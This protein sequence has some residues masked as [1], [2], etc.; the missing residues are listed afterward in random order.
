MSDL[1]VTLRIKTDAD[2]TVRAVRQV[3]QAVG[4]L[5]PQAQKSG[6][7]AEQGM[8]RARRGVDAVSSS[9]DR[10]QRIAATAFAGFISFRAV[11]RVFRD[12]V[13]NTTDQEAVLAQLEAR[14]QSTGGAAGRSIAQLTT[15]SRELQ[16][17]TTVAN[18]DIERMMGTLMTF[19]N[20]AGDQF[21]ASTRAILN[22]SAALGTDLQS[23]ALQVGKALNDPIR[24][25]DGLNRSGIQFNDT[26]REM[27]RDMAEA[28]DVAGAQRLILAELETQFGGAAEAAR[29]TFG[30]ALAGLRNAFDDLLK[31]Q[32]DL[33]SLTGQ[34]E[35]ITERLT[36]PALAEAIQAGLGAALALIPPA[37]DAAVMGLEGFVTVVTV[38]I[39]NVDLLVDGVI[40]LATVITTRLVLALAAKSAA[41]LTT[42]GSLNVLNVALLA[43][44]V[45][46]QALAAASRAGTAAL[47][48][49]GG[50]I[51]VVALALGG[52]VF[53]VRRYQRH[54]EEL[55]Q[56][57]EAAASAM[58]RMRAATQGA[59]ETEQID[60]FRA[61]TAK[62]NQE[63]RETEEALERATIARLSHRGMGS[64]RD[65][66]E[67]RA[68]RERLELYLQEREMLQEVA[69]ERR[70]LN[71]H[72]TG[73]AHHEDLASGLELFSRAGDAAIDVL[74]RL[75]L[76]TRNAA[77]GVGEMAAAREAITDPL[78]QQIAQ[79]EREVGVLELLAEGNRT[80]AEAQLEYQYQLDLTA[81]READAEDAT[82]N[83]VAAVERK[84][85]RLRELNGE[86]QD[87]QAASEAAAEAE[88][89]H[90]QRMQQLTQS[91]GQLLTTTNPLAARQ[92]ELNSQLEMMTELAGLSSE[93]LADMGVNGQLLQQVIAGLQQEL[94]GLGGDSSVLP[95][96]DVESYLALLDDVKR[97][98][99]EIADIEWR[100]DRVIE[101][102]DPLIAELG[103]VR[104]Q[105]A[106]VDDA[107]NKGLISEAQAGFVRTGVAANAAFD[108]VLSG[109]DS[110]SK[111]YQELAVAQQ[112]MNTL[113]G[114][115]AILQTAATAPWPM[116]FVAMAQMAAMVASLIGSLG[117]LGGGG[118]NLAE[119]RQ[120]TQG[121]GT[122]LGD[123]DAKSETIA[124][125]LEITAD[126]TSTLVGINRGMLHALQTMQQGIASAATLVARGSLDIDLSALNLGKS[127]WGF[128][129]T[130]LAD[131]GI[132][133]M[134][135]AITEMVDGAVAQAFT[136]TRRSN[137]FSTSYR[138][139]FE[140]LDDAINDQ[141]NLIFDS[142]IDS[143]T[144]AGEALGIP[145]DEIQS[146]IEQFE[147]AAQEISLEGLSAEEQQEELEAVFSAIF[148]D[149]AG[150]VI[151]F[152]DQFQQIGEGLGETLVR[153][154]TSVQ[155]TEEAMKRL[156][157]AIDAPDPERMA[158]ISVGLVEALG[159]IEQFITGMEGF[160]A[161]FAPESHQLSIATDD[162]TRAL[163]GV[164]LA[165]PN[166][167]DEMWQLMGTLD[168]STE[169][170]REQFAM[171]I[172][173]RD[174][175][176]TYYSH[177]E[178]IQNERLGLER[179]ILQLQGDTAALRE[180]ELEKLDDSNRALQLRIWALEEEAEL[181][182][183]MQGV[184]DEIARL[185]LHPLVDEFR[186][187]EKSHRDLVKRASELGASQQQLD[188]IQELHTIRLEQLSGRI[189][190]AIR[191]IGE[192]LFGGGAAG[193]DAFGSS[194][195]API[196]DAAN[197]IRDSLI[198]AL[199][200]VDEWLR[201]SAFEDP[202]LTKPQQFGA[203]QDEFE[204]LIQIAL[205]GEGQEQADA[206]SML[207]QLA[208]QLE[209]LGVQML[210]SA[211]PEFQSF[212]QDLIA[213]MEQV[214]GIEVPEE[215][216]PPTS[217]QV[218]AIQGAVEQLT[219]T[220]ADQA[221]LAA[222]LI[223][224]V[225]SLADITGQSPI[226]L[227][228]EMGYPLRDL[229]EM[230][231]GDIDEMSV[232]L[233]HQLMAVANA[234][235]ADLQDV[236]DAIGVN[237]GSLQEQDSLLSQA[238][239]DVVLGLPEE[240]QDELEEHLRNVWE[241]TEA[242]D[243]NEALDD[244]EKVTEGLPA[245]YRDLLKPFFDGIDPSD[246]LTDQLGL[247]E[248][249]KQIEQ[250]QLNAMQGVA[251]VLERVRKNL[252]AANGAAD[253]PGYA[254]GGWASGII[255]TGEIGPELVL[256][257][258]V[259][260]FL[261]RE[262]LPVNVG[263]GTDPRVAD[264]LLQLV[265]QGQQAAQQ[266]ER[267]GD[268]QVQ[269]VSHLSSVM[270][271]SERRRASERGLMA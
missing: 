198:R 243:A 23:A 126:A 155:V 67:E 237:I 183:M 200:G 48:L 90:S 162:L 250:Q 267:L 52:M 211:T 99:E 197:R 35:L 170:G 235:G 262:G 137:L 194:F 75:G 32:G 202:S 207:P 199:D 5:G 44:T 141:I 89:E 83:N 39:E 104:D 196:E 22:I 177:L 251:A 16:N 218:G 73:Q 129:S 6:R 215:Q 150:A 15:L 108:A 11:N 17:T 212:Y 247:L 20:I 259:S 240:I 135:G 139:Q 158:Q 131:Q 34:V 246:P 112:T 253:I 254:T 236:S 238:L 76:V 121:T 231:I 201:R 117:S 109:M 268:Q 174:A 269:V 50:P 110:S 42:A 80:A 168:A 245:K 224:L 59:F 19:T 30:G 114:I 40:L 96:A 172:E 181:S 147:V 21:D 43:A 192:Q 208:S 223:E 128:T 65:S 115:G 263:G 195:S 18:E 24:G 182:D 221:D 4:G 118:G 87:Y 189:R 105:I 188:R 31:F 143:V 9:L 124:Q 78:N 239:Q 138:T 165:V 63:I 98:M 185:T 103:H 169:A 123:P 77:G 217:A 106:A 140:E 92:L 25:M 233:V 49:M 55:S 148:D 88:Q 209:Q 100:F 60:E 152:I 270:I 153:V 62:L 102:F 156:G 2:G 51:G 226:E 157:L 3:N 95:G 14:I 265:E 54:L 134:G 228:Q 94:A 252:S 81:A 47:A 166:T 84:Y 161:K 204:R 82:L 38:V 205:T 193:G 216:Q 256:P 271:E 130:K 220:A 219:L 173:L 125:A 151:P 33:P 46:T 97:E 227:L 113:L 116:N 180:L 178:A 176:D 234:L 145:L 206:I 222:Q 91:Y 64:M 28:G 111:S 230:L 56:P 58:E 213:Q 53:A 210:G 101:S 74:E 225:G 119:R 257:H 133:L 72:M 127:D 7:E 146:R 29:G 266:R 93:Q 66:G 142:M 261:A 57:T 159:G 167:R 255:R 264:Y 242:A 36:D 85:A 71:E 10:V 249:I 186:N 45:Q 27:I 179:R 232:G 149:L 86:L 70:R 107:L 8:G 171:L 41:L 136:T 258:D 175:A 37:I 154:A 61:S 1:N 260:K 13:S 244:L 248:S 69:R 190:E 132:A 79:L 229:V 122:V 160:V 241:A 191:S 12:I 184:N 214:S 164:G 203:M 187:L 68:L 120:E 144:A 26:Q 163:E